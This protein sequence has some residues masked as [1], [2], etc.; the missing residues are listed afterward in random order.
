MNGLLKQ[1]T[2]FPY[3][4]FCSGYVRTRK[5][6]L[7]DLVGENLLEPL[8]ERL[9]LLGKLI[10]L[11]LQGFVLVSEFQS[12]FGGRLEFVSTKLV[13]RLKQISVRK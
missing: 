12:R 5:R 4:D 3:Y 13:Q 8:G 11:L 10:F 6:T 1:H 9:E 2:S 7:F